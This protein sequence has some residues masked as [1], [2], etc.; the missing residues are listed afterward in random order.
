MADH[1]PVLAASGIVRRYPRRGRTMFG[2]REGVVAV[3]GVTLHVV[4]REIYGLVGLSG[5]GKSTLARVLAG[6]EE[7]D[8]GTVVVAGRALEG[9]GREH[10]GDRR[11]HVQLVFQEPSAALDPLHSVGRIVA[12]PLVVHRLV[13]RGRRLERISRLLESV[14]LPADAEFLGRRPSE[15]SGG[16]RQ[17]VA[18]A[19]ALACEPRVLLLDEPVSALDV[20]V[21][22]QVLNLLTEL[23]SSLGVSILLIAH[24]V[25][26]VRHVADRVGVMLGGHIVEEGPA[27]EVL[28]C[29]RHPFTASLIVAQLARGENEGD[30]KERQDEAERQSQHACP[31]LQR[32]PRQAESCRRHPALTEVSAG[33]LV[34]CYFP[35]EG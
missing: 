14:G 16:E 10:G 25:A 35:I 5:A 3:A 21:R 17:R 8:E 20:S 27:D 33:H 24:D 26:V 1:V 23:R 18:I 29:P 12:E 30:R 9:A 11:S 15:L 31:F 13:P 19:R 4:D 22:G 2:R 28:G 34:A 32:C 6:L 7:P